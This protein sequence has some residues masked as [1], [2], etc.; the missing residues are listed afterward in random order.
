MINFSI[1]NRGVT[2][3]EGKTILQVALEAGIYIPHL[4]N[5][6]AVKPYAACRMCLVE[7]TKKGRKKL[8]TACDYPISNGLEVNS[9]TALVQKNRKMVL[10][11]LLV[12]SPNSTVLWDMAKKIGVEKVRFTG[13]DVDDCILCGLCVRT[14]NEVVGAHAIGF[15]S[16]GPSRVVSTPFNEENPACIACGACSVVC[17]VD[18]IP[19]FEHDGI[20]EMPR[21]H[22]KAQLVRCSKCKKYFAT[23][24]ELK[25]IKEK[26]N[27][28]EEEILVC[29][30]CRKYSFRV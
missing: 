6:D 25:F 1:N 8:V 30:N 16:R 19:M 13:Q 21:W 4:C 10:E 14:C 26:S 22:K 9:N 23:K 24:E 15:E 29:P 11:L 28:S 2:G 27:L 18:I 5:N 7:V 12:R 20:R 3:S 17:P